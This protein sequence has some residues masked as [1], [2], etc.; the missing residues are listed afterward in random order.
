MTEGDTMNAKKTTVYINGRKASKE[1]RERLEQ[2]LRS[3]RQRA[4]AHVTK[5]G[6]IAYKTKY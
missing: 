3:G 4:T 5:A 1:D 2:D 6:A